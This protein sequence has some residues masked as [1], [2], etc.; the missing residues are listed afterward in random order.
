MAN[1]WFRLYA[2]FAHDH[3]VQTLSEKD[4]RR[5]I[6]LFCLRCNGYVTLQD[7]YVTFQLRVTDIEWQESKAL[8]ID[9]GFIDSDNNI[10][11]WDKR[12][13]VSDSSAERVAKHRD[14][15]KRECNVTVT[16][17]EQNRTD[18]EHKKPLEKP[19]SQNLA[20]QVEAMK[21]VLA[22]KLRA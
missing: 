5:L 18:S 19:A 4:Q 12:Q 8:F 13:F 6:M 7:K 22:E 17:P 14:K 2:E 9:L 15:V 11:N 20:K 1:P 16:P 3:K 21:N 10:L